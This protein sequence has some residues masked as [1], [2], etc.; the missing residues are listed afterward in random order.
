M[1]SKIEFDLNLNWFKV[2][3]AL[4]LL[5]LVMLLS[6]LFQ[7]L[8]LILTLLALFG[9]LVFY[10]LFVKEPFIW[11]CLLLFA[12]GLEVWGRIT[13]NITVF[14]VIYILSLIGFSCYLLFQRSVQQLII[15]T[16]IN[17]Y[18]FAYLGFSLFSLIY[19]PNLESG[20]IYISVTFALFVFFLL[21][22]NFVKSDLHLRLVVFTLLLMNTFVT[23]LLIYQFIRGDFIPGVMDASI[24]TGGF[25][26]Y[27][28]VGTFSDPNVAATFIATG[29]IL[30]FS[31]LIHSRDRFITKLI[32]LF[33]SLISI[34]GIIIT[35][36]RSGWI[37]LTA[38]IFI[39]LFFINNKKKLI[40]IIIFFSLL[41]ILATFTTPLGA[42]ISDR[43]LSIF[44]LLK[45][46]SIKARMLM[47]ESGIRMFFD[48]PIWGFGYRSFP[49]VYDYYINPDMPWETLY[50]KESHTLFVCLLAELGVIGFVIVFLWFKRV[51]IDCFK[52]IRVDKNHFT[53]AVLIG[54]FSLFVAFNVNFLFYGNLFPQFNLIWLNFGII[55]TITLKQRTPLL[56]QS[57]I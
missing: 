21:I 20:I 41:V 49:L 26:F 22:V 55:Y 27:R 25:K 2:F 24:I 32:Y 23:L 16:P 28:A 54:S 52:F 37:F 43:F 5:E 35:F 1:L 29:V 7:P 44:E 11:I 51:L 36:S 48:S 15:N 14:H 42:L 50:I 18:I 47:G 56:N 6:G 46:P 33:G 45:D 57:S 38:G 53:K 9:V 30:A 17:K 31:L 3:L 34:I 40:V 19:S 10:L 4:F 13:E 12:S 8:L 39:S